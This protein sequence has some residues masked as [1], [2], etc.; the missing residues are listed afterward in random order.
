MD[1]KSAPL[2]V[3][4]WRLS[5]GGCTVTTADLAEHIQIKHRHATINRES[6]ISSAVH[7]L[8]INEGINF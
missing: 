2:I 5:Q 6:D 3:D 1:E 8:V 7:S 4:Q